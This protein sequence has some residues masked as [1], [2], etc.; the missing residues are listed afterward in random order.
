LH[1]GY[2]TLVAGATIFGCLGPRLNDDEKRFFRD[3]NP[4][5]FILFARNHET[6]DQIR[7]L[8]QE[9][10]ETVGRDAPILID[11]EGGRVQR[12]RAP[13]WL[14]WLPALDQVNATKPGQV[15]R[16]MWIR[17]RLIAAELRDLGI[18][19]NCA[20]MLD[21]ATPQVHEIIRNRCYGFDATTVAGAGRAVADGLLSGGVLPILKHIPGHG[22]PI[23]DSHHELPR[24]DADADELRQ[25]DFAPFMAL[26]NLPMAMTGHVVYEAFDRENCATLSP[27][28][29]DL[30]R[31]EIGFDGLLMTDDIS[32]NAVSGSFAS[33]SRDALT[34][35]CDLILHCHGHMHEMVE[36]ADAAG[37]LTGKG[38]AR[39]ENALMARVEPG[40][41][42]RDNL[43]AELADLLMI[44][45]DGADPNQ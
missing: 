43:L 8:T 33:R 20:P 10:R 16:A 12:L 1:S 30:I 27:K 2:G 41:I 25:V 37:N 32:M 38:C 40:E 15:A 29:I 34:A 24:T 19:V 5:G 39:A 42:D 7:V 36:V 4:W 9:L 23:A 17:Y 13:N 3:A 31:K 14:E 26:A 18:D 35:G 6:P 28:I 11:Q 44:S 45:S 21:V 22:R